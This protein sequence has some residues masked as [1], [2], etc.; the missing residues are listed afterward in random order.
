MPLTPEQ[1]QRLQQ[2]A[3]TLSGKAQLLVMYLA[4][5]GASIAKNPSSPTLEDPIR[6]H[7]DN[8]LEALLEFHKALREE[9]HRR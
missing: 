8:V 5:V 2:S 7:A 4:Q 3:T 9:F 6:Y 1:I